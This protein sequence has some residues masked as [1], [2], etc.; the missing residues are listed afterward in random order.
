MKRVL[1]T[2]VMGFIG[3]GVCSALQQAGCQ[4][5]AALR[6]KPLTT[7]TDAMPEGAGDWVE[8]GDIGPDTEWSHGLEGMDA[9]VHLAGRAH[10]LREQAPDP[11]AAFRRVNVAGTERLAQSAAAMG[12]KRLVFVSTVGIH[13]RTTQDRPFKESDPPRPHN[14]YTQSKWEGEQVL[15]QIARRTSLEVVVVRPPLVYGPAVGAHFLQLM[16]LI[17]SGIPLPLSL[18][19]NRRSLVYLGNL[20]DLLVHTVRCTQAASETYL[21]SDEENI[22]TLEL[23]RKL[24]YHLGKRARLF[25]LGLKMLRTVASVVGKAEQADGLCG[26]LVVDSGKSRRHLHREE[27]VSLEKGLERTATWYRET[28]RS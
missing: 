22:S 6:H 23:I 24:A 3:G 19:E 11:L 28:A 8:V 10:V 7:G 25:P 12:V 1:V 2:G 5:R 27:P 4:V 16:R 26:S 15:H 9:V 14:A 20:A 18:V 13:G 21:A 17:D